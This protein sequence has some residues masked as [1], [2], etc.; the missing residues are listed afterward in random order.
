MFPPSKIT[1]RLIILDLI[2]L[3]FAIWGAFA[4]RL[5]ELWPD[6]LSQNLLLVVLLVFTNISA[7]KFTG[8][9]H[10]HIKYLGIFVVKRLV[11]ACFFTVIF[12]FFIWEFF[13]LN[14]T[15]QMPKT[16][17]ILIFIFSIGVLVINRLFLMEFLHKKDLSDVIRSKTLIYGAGVAGMQLSKALL[18]SPDFKVVGFIDDNTHLH[19][20]NINGIRVYSRQKIQDLI[21]AHKVES[22][23]LAMPSLNL[24]KRKSLINELSNYQIKVLTMPSLMELMNG[25]RKINELREILIEDLLGRDE[26]IPFLDMLPACI[27]NKV[28]MVTGAGG[29]I[30]SELCR[31]IIQ[32]QPTIIIIFENNEYSLYQIEAELKKKV[33]EL[34]I[35]TRVLGILGN[36]MH[37]KRLCRVM[38]KYTVQTLYHAA[39]YKHVPIV[40]HNMIEGIQNN[41]FGTLNTA[42]AAIEAKVEKFVLISTD[43]AVRPT[44]IMGATKRFAELIL[45]A[46]ATGQ[47]FTWKEQCYQNHNTSFCMVRFGNVL[48]SSGSVVPL[49]RQQI[50]AGGPVT[51]T[52]K[53]I[54]RYFMTIPEAAQL[55]IQAGAL[56]VNGEVFLLDMGKAVKIYDLARKMIELS[57]YSVKDEENPDGDINIIFSGLRPGEKLYE[58][59]LI[60]GQPKN[61]AHPMIFSAAEQSLNVSDL[62]HYLTNLQL[63]SYDFD[64]E[65]VR[66]ILQEAIVGYIPAS[67]ICD[68][69]ASKVN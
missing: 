35:N 47:S 60:D 66:S 1:I 3:L 49:F 5:N 22:I 40:E 63:A 53:E 55:V 48:E 45:Q 17:W 51:V 20:Q 41:I 57:G 18:Q 23:L 26:V 19:K 56:S 4:L 36:V 38:E 69:L 10:S 64:F 28:V 24:S 68:Y 21:E 50:Q 33:E 29:S 43:K 16:C 31:Q 62:M 25:T 42:L 58:E 37:K 8:V 30:G 14:T 67:D 6:R 54:N 32:H 52:H 15:L 61:T 2:C 13:S 11:I 9:Y 12:C 39:A 7:L 46:L 44:N 27:Q 59:L 34:Q 65:V